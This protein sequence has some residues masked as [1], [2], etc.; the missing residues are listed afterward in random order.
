MEVSTQVQETSFVVTTLYWV[1]IAICGKP[2]SNDMFF[3]S[4]WWFSK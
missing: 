1:K 3:E 4:W 2:L